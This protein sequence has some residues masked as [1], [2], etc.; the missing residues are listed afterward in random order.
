MNDEDMKEFILQKS[1][2]EKARC[3]NIKVA[4][5]NTTTFDLAVK[6]TNLPE[7]EA[8]RSPKEILSEMELLDTETNNV[9]TMIKRLI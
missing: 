2:P 5:L 8:L 6:N 1:N 3:W 7:E 4:D 9:L